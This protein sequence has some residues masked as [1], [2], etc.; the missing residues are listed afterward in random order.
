MTEGMPWIGFAVSS[1]PPPSESA[2]SDGLARWLTCALISKRTN[3]PSVFTTAALRCTRH[4]RDIITGS[5]YYRN[6]SFWQV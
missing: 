6:G 5:I 2:F 4:D 1:P 3:Q